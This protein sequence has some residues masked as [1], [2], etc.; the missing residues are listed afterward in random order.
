[1]EQQIKVI[2]ECLEGAWIDSVALENINKALAQL[3]QISIQKVSNE[4]TSTPIEQPVNSGSEGLIKEIEAYFN[5]K[6]LVISG[7]NWGKTQAKITEA[8]NLL[9]KCK[10]HLSQVKPSVRIGKYEIYPCQHGGLWIRHDSG[11]GMQVTEDIFKKFYNDN[12]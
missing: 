5:P 12:F 9:H 3:E 2:R 4:C 11:E 6:T 10:T 7:R 1:M 8:A